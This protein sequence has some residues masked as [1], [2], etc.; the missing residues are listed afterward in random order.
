MG[1]VMTIQEQ[2]LTAAAAAWVGL[3]LIWLCA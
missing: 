1:A 2:L 3:F